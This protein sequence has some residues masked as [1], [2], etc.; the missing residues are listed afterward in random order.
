M[1]FYCHLFTGFPVRAFSPSPQNIH[2][3]YIFVMNIIVLNILHGEDYFSPLLLDLIA[4]NH[5]F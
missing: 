3:I 4:V 1:A 5:S 2:Q